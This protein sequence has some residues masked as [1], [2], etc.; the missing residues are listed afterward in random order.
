MAHAYT[1]KRGK[2][3]MSK[4]GVRKDQQQNQEK[5]VTRVAGLPLAATP[6][7]FNLPMVQVPEDA[8]GRSDEVRRRQA[9]RV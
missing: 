9:D 8:R 1:T 5:C 3:K 2:N 6:S 4:L 7:R